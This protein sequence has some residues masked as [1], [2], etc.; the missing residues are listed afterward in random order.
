MTLHVIVTPPVMMTLAACPF[1]ADFQ[2]NLLFEGAAGICS[3]NNFFHSCKIAV[4]LFALH[5]VGDASSWAQVVYNNCCLLE[6]SLQTITNG[7]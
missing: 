1:L 7:H 5:R 6:K 2:S 4:V 3:W